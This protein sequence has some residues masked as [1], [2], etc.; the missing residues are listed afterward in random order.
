MITV[1]DFVMLGKTVP[2]PISDGRVLVC[3]AGV[4]ETMRSLIRVYPLAKRGS[5]PRWTV[6]SVDLTRN[7]KDSR[8]ESFCLAGDHDVDADPNFNSA[9]R[10]DGKALS[11]AKRKKLLERHVV[12]SIAEA[13][14]K[15]LSLAIVH[16]ERLELVFTANRDSPDSPELALFDMWPRPI[17]GAKRFAFMPRLKFSDPRG[18]HDLKLNDWGSY[19]FLRKYGDGRR[20]ELASA[21]GLDRPRSL[22][23]GNH[24]RHRTA[25]LVIS[26]LED[27]RQDQVFSC[28]Q[29][30]AELLASGGAP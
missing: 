7:P 8:P 17:A 10:S 4:S 9:F 24:N 16:P 13:N 18:N 3:S 22:L 6:N 28:F 5:P 1:H 29:P 20:S 25:W 27:L 15:R 11:R 23:I 21:L 12:E 14:E 19:E 26:V 2:E 30:S